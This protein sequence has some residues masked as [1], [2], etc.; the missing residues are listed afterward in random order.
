MCVCVCVCVCVC[1]FSQDVLNFKGYE[2]LSV[3]AKLQTKCT[4]VILLNKHELVSE[5][6]LDSALDDIYE[7]NLDTPKVC[8]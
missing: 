7:L 8:V 3:T 4:D 2:D 1:G 5:A 6:Q